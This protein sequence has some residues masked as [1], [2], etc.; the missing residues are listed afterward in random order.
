MHTIDS[1]SLNEVGGSPERFGITLEA[2]H[3]QNIERCKSRPLAMLATSTHDTK[4]SEDVRARI[5]VLSEIPK[6]WRKK[7]Y[8]WNRQNQKHKVLV[9]GKPAPNRNEEYLL[10]QTLVGV[11]PFCNPDE[12][13]FAVFRSR[14]REYM[15]KSLGRPRCI[16][17]GSAP[18]RR[19]RM[20]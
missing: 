14:I 9:D 16:Q 20:R 19:T 15:L 18:T 5:N 6:Q 7:L 3:G 12:D 1:V 17:A 2:F 11:W 10:Y 13:E 4:R 8:R